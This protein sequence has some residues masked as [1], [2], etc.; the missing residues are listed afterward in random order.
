MVRPNLGPGREKSVG[1]FYPGKRKTL[2]GGAWPGGD[3]VARGEHLPHPRGLPVS[4]PNLDERA[5][6]GANHVVQECV[7]RHVDGNE[8]LASLLNVGDLNALEAARRGLALSGRR[9]A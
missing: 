1:I 3:P 6:D 5:G 9:L 4:P 8:L 2:R 7:A